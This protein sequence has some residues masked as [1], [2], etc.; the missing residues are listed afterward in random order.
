MNK[1]KW[2]PL[3]AAAGAIVVLGGALAALHLTQEEEET[4]I[5]LWTVTEPDLVSYS[6]NGLEVTLRKGR[7]G[8]WM[9]ESDPTLPLKQTTVDTLAQ[10]VTA[11]TAQRKL[12]GTD[13]TELPDRS[14]TPLILLTLGQGDTT[15]TLTVDSKNNIA[16]IYY[17]YDEQGTVYTA[18]MTAVDA[19]LKTPLSLYQPQTITEQ[20]AENATAMT[21]NDWSFLKTDGVWTLD[22]EPDDALDQDAVNK[23]VRTVCE[24]QTQW[25]ITSPGTDE[26]YGLD[27]PDVTVK[28]TFEDGTVLN[29]AFGALKPGDETVCYLRAS[30]LPGTV[31][32]VSAEHRAA[33]AFTRESLAAPEPEATESPAVDDIIAEKPIGGADD[34]ADSQ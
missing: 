14:E 6:G 29:A 10:E 26:S 7:E 31:L 34:Y 4:G 13:L 33:Y 2:L 21:V 23:M 27:V 11:L 8:D 19:L 16:G 28:L 15:Q 25:T 3:A 32:E 22:G 20:A 18:E 30:T 9:L 24:L 1:K 17:V 12:T 5:A